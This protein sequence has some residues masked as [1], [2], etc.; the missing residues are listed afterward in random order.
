[1][2]QQFFKEILINVNGIMI[3]VQALE[4]L[5]ITLNIVYNHQLKKKNLK[6]KI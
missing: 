1:M 4:N 5:N 2:H 3:G 6:E